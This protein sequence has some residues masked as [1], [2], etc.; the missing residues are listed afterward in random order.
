LIIVIRIFKAIISGYP[1]PMPV[2]LPPYL[3]I[4]KAIIEALNLLR[5]LRLLKKSP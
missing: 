1:F 3:E 5:N 4:T 2:K